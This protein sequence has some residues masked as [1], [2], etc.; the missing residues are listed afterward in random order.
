MQSSVHNDLNTQ[1]NDKADKMLSILNETNDIS[2][3][4]S[5]ELVTQT[6]IFDRIEKNLDNVD[7]NLSI[8]R[9]IINRMTS[10]FSLFSSSTQESE[11][12][13]A[14]E[15]STNKNTSVVDP[16]HFKDNDKFDEILKS[17]GNIKSQANLQGDI[18]SNHNKRSEEMILQIEKNSNDIKKLSTDMKKI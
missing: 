16:T 14:F 1:I 11:K 18:L 9:K 5:N 13:I 12:V 8:S 2:N 3:K 15:K 6:E 4:I 10:F 7:Q 17:L